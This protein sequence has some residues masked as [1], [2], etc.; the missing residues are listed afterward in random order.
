MLLLF[1]VLG[2]LAPA[3]AVVWFMNA[4][5]R[6]PA[7][8]ARRH[9]L[10]LWSSEMAL[11]RDQVD[12]AWKARA[13]ALDRMPDLRAALEA[14]GAVAVI[15]LD[16]SPA[17]PP[18]PALAGGAWFAA[19]L[20]EGRGDFA[21]AAEAYAALSRSEKEATAAARAGEARV[22]CLLRS[23]SR[24]AALAEVERQF[25]SGRLTRARDYDGRS[26][27]ASEILLA[28]RLLAAHD[29]RR[30]VFLQRMHALLE[31][32]PAVPPPQRLFLMHEL[33]AVAPELA[34]FSTYAAE[35][36]AAHYV[37]SGRAA[38]GGAE[39]ESAG[40]AHLWKLTSPSRKVIGLYG[41]A[42]V[43]ALTQSTLPVFGNV[44]PPGAAGDGDLKIA[45]NVLAGWKLAAPSSQSTLDAA[46]HRRTA[47]YLWTGYLV[48]A[49]LVL[50][51]IVAGGAFRRQMRLTRLKT[52]LVAAVSHELKTPLASMRLL[53][54][55]LL[56]EDRPD[57]ARTRD[58]LELMAAENQ[59]LSRLIDNF[60]TFS[61]IERNRQSFDFRPTPPARIVDAALTSM[62]AR[63]TAPG[64]SLDVSVAPDLP[65]VS[66]DEDAVTT[67]LL[68]LL[69]NAY[70]YTSAEKHIAVRAWRAGARVLI[71]VTDNGIGIGPRDRKRIFRRFYQVDR[72]LA[73]ETGGC[74]LGLSIVDFIVRAHGGEVALESSP[75]QGSTFTVWLPAA[76]RA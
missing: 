15:P 41:T 28:L 26:I 10:D 48:L 33:P 32:Y 46:A 45:S 76:A 66:A 1:V 53:V 47:V 2:V 19:V 21:P 73:R 22:R 18:P 6:S 63:L 56:A 51:G 50:T 36:T 68:N 34:P 30:A 35:S 8:T 24:A 72:R 17:E 74:G 67:V 58:Y 3:A 70:K 38:P 49:A 75:G 69:D 29:S 4:A 60:L 43:I 23:G 11:F 62:G 65:D 40:P 42:T 14:S 9:V 64:C 37:E 13:A 44:L 39:L 5:A 52:D 54:D 61:R 25:L 59:R 12:A 20:L 71:A 27:A 57:P 7:E 16:P 55:N 31:D